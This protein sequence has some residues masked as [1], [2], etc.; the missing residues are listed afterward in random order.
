MNHWIRK[1]IVLVIGILSV[2]G[3]SLSYD[4]FVKPHQAVWNI[5]NPVHWNRSLVP[6]KVDGV[7]P[8]ALKDAV[9][10]WNGQADCPLFRIHEDPTITVK[11]GTIEVG[12]KS[13]EWG[14]GAFVNED[15]TRGEI[16][17][18]IPLMVGTDVRVLHHEL[19]HILGLAHDMEYTMKP[20]TQ[21]EIGG[22]G[23]MQIIRAQ[24]KDIEALNE[25]YCSEPEDE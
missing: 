11:Q 2:L 8:E 1:A 10:L 22:N 21:E 6:L 14:A 9:D 17:V 15:R 12:A 19:G 23:P 25:R 3:I 16:V 4:H 5:D 13:E 24:D 18:Y 7:Y 20:V